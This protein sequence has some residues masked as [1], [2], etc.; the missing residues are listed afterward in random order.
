MFVVPSNRQ[1]NISLKGLARS[2]TFSEKQYYLSKTDTIEFL[3]MYLQTIL[4]RMDAFDKLD[5]ED[6]R[7][8]IEV[9]NPDEIFKEIREKSMILDSYA[10]FLG[11]LQKLKNI[12]EGN[13]SKIFILVDEFLNAIVDKN[14][15]E[16]EGL[17]GVSQETI[18]DI[19]KNERK[20][21]E[22]ESKLEQMQLSMLHQE[23]TIG[24]LKS[25]LNILVENA[26]SFSNSVLPPPSAP[27][28]IGIG[29]PPPPPP[30][31]PFPAFGIPPPPPFG[32]PPPPPFGI[33]PPPSP[34]GSPPPPPPFG[35]PGF[36]IP[37]PPPGLGIP[38]PPGFGIPLPPGFPPPPGIGLPPP[39]LFGL[40]VAPPVPIKNKKNPKIP[41]KGLMWAS[42]AAT[43]IAG[44]IWEKIDDEKVKL[45]VELIEK[46]FV[47]LKAKEAKEKEAKEGGNKAGFFYFYK[48][49]M[50]F[51]FI[52]LIGVFYFFRV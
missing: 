25:Q 15:A 45:D 39:G 22:V 13:G 44:T 9:T 29:I 2:G 38:S 52:L 41:M 16:E 6:I 43:K 4:T 35:I 11:I 33:P 26:N 23:K 12:P 14:A 3:E 48:F 1:S 10:Y 28:P 36:G 50:F 19:F 51:T 40:A 47:N 30:P 24:N 18:R 20:L 32:I 37:P 21:K 8:S 49:L 17:D 5:L 27:P 34:F 42:V 46:E 31:P 7:A